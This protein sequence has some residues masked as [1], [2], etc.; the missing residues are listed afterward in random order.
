M[1]SPETPTYRESTF[2]PAIR[3]ARST[4]SSIA[5]VVASR[6]TTMPLR[7]PEDGTRPTPEICTSPSSSTSPT[8]AQTFVVPMSSPTMC[9]LRD[10]ILLT[11]SPPPACYIWYGSCANSPISCAKI[12]LSGSV[13]CPRP[14]GRLHPH[15][16]G[17]AQVEV[18]HAE[19]AVAHG[20]EQR[21]E[22]RGALAQAA[23]GPEAHGDAVRGH[24][25]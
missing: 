10:D 1:C 2:I 16:A 15:V 19:T 6:S 25:R 20:G 14:G 4:A 17:K 5:R 8:T 11:S 18:L 24:E 13:S 12:P 7:I 21:R 3:S 23:Q 22:Q 9:S